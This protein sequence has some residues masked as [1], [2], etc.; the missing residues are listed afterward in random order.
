MT[1]N[2]Y[3]VYGLLAL[4]VV[5]GLWTIQTTMLRAAI[6]LALVSAVLTL[7]MFEM[8]APLAGVF[9]LSVCA[10]LITV[11]F[12]ATISLT[13][14]TNSDDTKQLK[15]LRRRR[16]RPAILIVAIV[17]GLLMAKL[18]ALQLSPV[19]GALNTGA[20]REVLWNERRLDLVGQIIMIFVG[21][22]GV[23]VLFKKA[24]ARKET[25]G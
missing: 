10:G 2:T 20:V 21:V 5:L 13:R 9:E 22:Y 8:G 4:L 14:P 15:D 19:T 24:K 3:I 11:V 6:G 1:P 17:G 12:V 16:F 23:V 7:L 25:S 18:G